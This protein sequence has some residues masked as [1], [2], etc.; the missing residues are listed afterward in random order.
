MCVLMLIVHPS[1]CLYVQVYRISSR[2]KCKPM[3]LPS[4]FVAEQVFRGQHNFIVTGASLGRLLL[5]V[6]VN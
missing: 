1:I 6:I 3:D 2:E 4:G 5:F